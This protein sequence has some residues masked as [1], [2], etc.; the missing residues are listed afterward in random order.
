MRFFKFLFNNFL[1]LLLVAVVV[2]SGVRIFLNQEGHLE[3]L[4]EERAEKQLV[5]EEAQNEYAAIA[6]LEELSNTSESKET[7]IRERLNM[8]KKDEVQF[9][10][11]KE[12]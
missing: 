3:K 6:K 1:M 5:L 12:D 11:S 9:F 8:I 7:Q 2:I 10:F 4:A